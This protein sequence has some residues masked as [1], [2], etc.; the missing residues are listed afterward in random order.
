[1]HGYLKWVFAY[2]RTKWVKWLHG[3]YLM[4]FLPNKLSTSF[5]YLQLIMII[6][7][8]VGIGDLRKNLLQ[9]WGND[10]NHG[11]SK[12][13]EGAAIVNVKI[14]GR[15]FFKKGRMIASVEAQYH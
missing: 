4:L 14:R 11:G 15:I 12:S 1:M 10:S 6:W 5:L 7:L 2:K 3:H 8:V 9:V 13:I